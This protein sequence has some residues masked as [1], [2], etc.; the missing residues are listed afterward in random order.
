MKCSRPNDL[1]CFAEI[2]EDM[3]EANEKQEQIIEAIENK[4][5]LTLE[6]LICHAKVSPNFYINGTTPICT[7]ATQGN[8]AALAI[9]LRGNCILNTPN[10]RDDVW[11]RLPIHIAASK[12]HLAFLKLLLENFEDVN[13][14]DSDGRTALHWAAIFG[15]KDVA[16]LLL[17]SGANVNGAQ[18]DGFTPLYAATCFG[19]IDVCCTL[20]QYGGDAM[21]CDDDG[22][23]I[24]HTAANYGHL[25]ILKLISLKGPCLSCRTVD[26]ET[27]LHIAASSGHL[28]IVKYLEECGIGLDAQTNRGLTALHLSVQ[29]N[30]SSVFK[31]LLQAGANMYI[32]N[33]DMQSICYLVA[34]KMDS[35]FIK[36]LADAGYNFSTERWI[37]GNDFPATNN[38]NEDMKNYMRMNAEIPRTLLKMCQLRTARLLGWNYEALADS[39]PL[40]NY[41]K[42]L[43]KQ[44]GL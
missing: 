5:L 28:H 34:L 19:H 1:D 3:Y 38:M 30:K 15:N 44:T 4:D 14:K 31:F 16:E 23:N 21:V 41:L 42:N 11:Q 37:L 10:V 35:N 22:W 13:V 27:A 29:F 25:P 36:I 18:R 12:G 32:L 2:F 17:K 43:I 20:L 9:L 33:N 40:P 39:L 8:E 6:N 26:G 24:L 7:A